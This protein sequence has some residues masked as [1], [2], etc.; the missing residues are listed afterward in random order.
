MEDLTQ[1]APVLQRIQ[2]LVAEENVLRTKPSLDGLAAPTT[3][4]MA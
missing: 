2:R 1:E 4:T 3:S